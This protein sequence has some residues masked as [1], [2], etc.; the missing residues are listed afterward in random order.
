MVK[1]QRVWMVGGND[2]GKQ[3]R[4]GHAQN[5]KKAEQ[6]HDMAA[7]QFFEGVGQH[8]ASSFAFLMRGSARP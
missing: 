1:V 4:Q 7:K 3:G 8:Q 6:Q 5:D 2:W